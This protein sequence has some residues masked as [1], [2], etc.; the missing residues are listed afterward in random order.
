MSKPFESV[1]GGWQTKTIC[2]SPQLL[3]SL[4]A[5]EGGKVDPHPLEI[6]SKM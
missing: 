3:V 6:G 5:T 1:L 2:L 4:E